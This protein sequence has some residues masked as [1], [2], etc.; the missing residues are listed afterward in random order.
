MLERENLFSRLVTKIFYKGLVRFTK[1]TTNYSVDIS[2]ADFYMLS[3]KVI[4]ELKKA[5]IKKFFFIWSFSLGWFQQ[6]SLPYKR[7]KRLNGNSKWGLK[8]KLSL[9]VDCAISFP[10]HHLDL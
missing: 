8:S 9:A 5:F 4:N 1:N 6:T 7:R 10:L 2:N 3:N